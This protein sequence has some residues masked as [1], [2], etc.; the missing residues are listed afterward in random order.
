MKKHYLI[1]IAAAGLS[2]GL[3]SC[4]QSED[5]SED[6]QTLS[7]T[8]QTVTFVSGEETTNQANTRTSMGGAYTDSQFPFYWEGGDAIY[9]NAVQSDGTTSAGI[10][11]AIAGKVNGST[12]FS[13]QSAAIFTGDVTA[14]PSGGS[15][16]VRYTGTGT[17]TSNNQRD[18]TY[19][20]TTNSNANQLVIPPVQAMTSMDGSTSRIGANGD[21][22]TATAAKNASTGHYDFKLDH[23]AAYLILMPRWGTGG[24]NNTYKLKSVTVTTYDAHDTHFKPYLISGRFSYDDNGIGSVISKTNGS[25]AIKITIGGNAGALLTTTKGE[26][27][28]SINVAIKPIEAEIPLYCIYEVSDGTNTYYIEKI[29]SARKFSANSVTPAMA[30]LKAGYDLANAN[31][32]LNL[33]TNKNPYTGFYEWDAPAEYFVS[34]EM[35]DDYN[36]T[37]GIDDTAPEGD[38]GSR[39]WATYSNFNASNLPTY[40]QISWYL[41]GGCY[42]DA[43][44]VWGPGPNQKGGMWFKKKAYLISSGV[45]ADENTFNNSYGTQNSTLETKKP[46]NLET[47]WFFLPAPGMYATTYLD[48]VGSTGYYWSST[49]NWLPA[50]FYLAFGSS[51]PAAMGHV[52][53]RY[54]GAPIWSVQ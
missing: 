40:N 50:S 17:Y 18:A 33:I 27:A 39:N 16:K 10:S 38:E 21:C 45:V 26:Q 43:D 42:W 14:L 37:M 29:I 12:S 4:S 3:A 9:V 47:S 22:G 20:F 25:P 35:G 24:T 36:T 8:K 52:L 34:H 11:S 46:D 51:G 44:K 1:V 30:D 6:G 15:Y 13:K 54:D 48:G 32:Y 7:T 23:K 49:P 53:V 5:V 19:S 2:I 31:G 41:K 28:S